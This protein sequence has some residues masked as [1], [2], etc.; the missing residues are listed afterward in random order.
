M[1]KSFISDIGLEMSG[2]VA[3]L[4]GTALLAYACGNDLQASTP[5]QAFCNGVCRAEERC[6]VA[7]RAG[8]EDRCIQQR[9]G[10]AKYSL[11][12]AERLGDCASG[13]DCTTLFSDA[14]WQVAMKS[15]WDTARKEVE[16]TPKL[17]SFCASFAEAWFECGSWYSTADCEDAFGMWSDATLDQLSDCTVDSCDKLDAC[18]KGV[19]GS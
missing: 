1:K 18:E 11:D 4:L 2:K 3:C 13:F 5:A 8:C 9:P 17:R 7:A 15:C 16:P 14:G 10:L 19:L 12:G 6:S